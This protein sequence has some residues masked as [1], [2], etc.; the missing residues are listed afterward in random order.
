MRLL[1]LILA[2]LSFIHI[3]AQNDLPVYD[4]INEKKYSSDW[5]V[6]AVTIKAGI[7]KSADSGDIVLYNGLVKRV[8][9]LQPNIACIAYEN[10]SNNQQLLRAVKPEAEITIDGIK[11]NVGGLHGQTE[12]AYLLP[13]WLNNFTS[14][15]SDFHFAS[16]AVNDLQP[17]INW[18]PEGWALNKQQPTGKSISFNYTSSLAALKNVFVKVHYELYDGLPLIVKWISVENK[19]NHIITIAIAS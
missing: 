19:T 11:Y 3:H 12:N 17:Y 2:L 7:F 13:V 1:L 4:N 15:D 8:F 5:L 18:K 14:R 6:A 16:Y 9:R 10:M